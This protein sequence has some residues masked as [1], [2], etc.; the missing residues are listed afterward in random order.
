MLDLPKA[1]L[2]IFEEVRGVAATL[3]ELSRTIEKRSS[4]RASGSDFGLLKRS[5]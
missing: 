4:G 2:V 3:F 5:A 1:E